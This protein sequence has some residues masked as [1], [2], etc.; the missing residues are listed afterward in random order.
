M[1]AENLEMLS[2]EYIGLLPHQ[3]GIHLLTLK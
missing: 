1:Q 2:Y 3:K